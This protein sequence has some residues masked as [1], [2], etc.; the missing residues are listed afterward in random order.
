MKLPRMHFIQ[1]GDEH[2]V[3]GT[4]WRYADTTDEVAR[5][6]CERCKRYIRTHGVGA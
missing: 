5:V 2:P 1:S 6:T 3:C 4:D